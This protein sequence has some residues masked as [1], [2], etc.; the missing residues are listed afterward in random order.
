MCNIYIA[1][2]K[3]AYYYHLCYTRLYPHTYPTI[4]HIAFKTMQNPGITDKKF[5]LNNYYPIVQNLT[6]LITHTL[7]QQPPPLF[8]KRK[9]KQTK[10]YLIFLHIQQSKTNIALYVIPLSRHS[11]RQLKQQI[12][13]QI[14]FDIKIVP[15]YLYLKLEQHYTKQMKSNSKY[16]NN[17]CKIT[18]IRETILFY[19]IKKSGKLVFTSVELLINSTL[20]YFQS[21]Y[22]SL[23]LKQPFK[24]YKGKKKKKKKN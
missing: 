11:S 7:L 10:T 4:I 8:T 16:F 21:S 13:E 14:Y 23:I 9:K 17:I 22:Y 18:S 24:K 19:S 2:S 1:Q 15:K 5:H 6:L 3:T 12:Q 20:Y